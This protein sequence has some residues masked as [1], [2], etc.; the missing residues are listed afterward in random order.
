MPTV[1]VV[2]DDPITCRFMRLC[3]ERDG[4]AVIEAHSGGEAVSL[5]AQAPQL[6]V[7]VTDYRL[8]G[9]SGLDLVAVATRMD[10]NIPC[11][12][13]TGSTGLEVA[14]TAMSSGAIGYLVKPFTGEALR[15]VVA[16]AMERRRLAEEAMKLRV[17]V[18]LLERFTMLLADVVEA[19]DVET[20][21]HCRRLIA[22]SDR[23]AEALGVAA[24]ERKNTRLGAC[25]HDIGK[26]AIPDAVL[27]KP[28]QLDAVEWAVVRRHPELGASLLDGIDQWHDARMIVR[29]HHERWDGAGYPSRLQREQI[30]FG[31]R[32]VAVA[33]AV[34]VMTTGRRYSPARTTEHVVAEVRANR[35]TQFDPDV[36]DAFLSLAGVD[37][38][39]DSAMHVADD[40]EL[41][42]PSLVG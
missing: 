41:A 30:P 15:I 40:R 28:E 11:I 27:H 7:I 37:P 4:F 35:A 39:M 1:L 21:A 3:L 23:L 12:V 17:M 42:A 8:P 6:D 38:T 20:H 9:I 18:P 13:V 25:L 16:R 14:V 5:L 29:H 36:V 34:D 10:P 31:A 19:R 33:D 32:I 24:D 26:V 2:E 22:I